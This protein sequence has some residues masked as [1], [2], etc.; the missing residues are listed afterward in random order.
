[1]EWRAGQQGDREGGCI[2]VAVELRHSYSRW[3]ENKASAEEPH[4]SCSS[5][6]IEST[7]G[8]RGARGRAPAAD[9]Q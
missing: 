5:A 3:G 4:E 6:T 1:M 8:D 9:L 7:G 2:S